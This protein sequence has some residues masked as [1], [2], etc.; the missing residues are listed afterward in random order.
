[1]RQKYAEI[2]RNYIMFVNLTWYVL[3]VWDFFVL[4]PLTAAPKGMPPLQPPPSYGTGKTSITIY[5][6][7]RYF[8]TINIMEEIFSIAQHYYALC[9]V[10]WAT[11]FVLRYLSIS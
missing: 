3:G 6:V 10:Q 1:M 11:S 9:W 2:G 5:P 4:C 7:S 8:Y